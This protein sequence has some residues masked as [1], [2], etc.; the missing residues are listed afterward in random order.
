[1]TSCFSENVINIPIDKAPVGPGITRLNKWPDVRSIPPL[2]S[3]QIMLFEM[4]VCFNEISI[5]G[6]AKAT[7]Y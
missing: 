3:I 1:M 7:I 5:L 4:Q 2:E 6:V